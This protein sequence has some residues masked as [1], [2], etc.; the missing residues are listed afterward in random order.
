MWVLHVALRVSGNL[1]LGSAHERAALA[2]AEIR[3]AVA[4]EMDELL[5]DMDASYKVHIPSACALH[6]LKFQTVL[7]YLIC[8]IISVDGHRS[9]QSSHGWLEKGR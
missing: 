8:A 3:E 2:E 9:M 1:Q 6:L 4:G 7:C 5:R